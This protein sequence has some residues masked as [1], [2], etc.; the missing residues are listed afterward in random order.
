MNIKV[1]DIV[2]MKHSPHICG[3]V[4]YVEFLKSWNKHVVTFRS[5]FGSFKYKE[6]YLLNV[7]RR[8]RK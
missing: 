5:G 2:R 4:L 6:P 1:G 7:I 8:K 3:E